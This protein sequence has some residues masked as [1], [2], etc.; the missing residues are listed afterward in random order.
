MAAI[1]TK[2]TD[3]LVTT[4]TNWYEKDDVFSKHLGF[5]MIINLGLMII[6]LLVVCCRSCIQR[7]R[8]LRDKTTTT[9][10]P[11]TIYRAASQVLPS[12]RV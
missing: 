10:Q 2:T 1:A 12:S 3:E 6:T 9:A 5:I 7:R 8:S 11:R 4:I